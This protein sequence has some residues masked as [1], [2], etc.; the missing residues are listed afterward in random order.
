MGVIA[1]GAKD[2][3]GPVVD[4]VLLGIFVS[5]LVGGANSLYGVLAGGM[6]ELGWLN[7]AIQAFLLVISGML[8]FGGS[9]DAAPSE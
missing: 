4:A 5:A 2:S 6:G 9:G 7:V 1:W 8:R 3:S